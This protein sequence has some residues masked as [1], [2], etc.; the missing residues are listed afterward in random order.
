VN[1]YLGGHGTLADLQED[2]GELGLSP[3]AQDRLI[4]IVRER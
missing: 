4:E 1:G 2:L 3:A